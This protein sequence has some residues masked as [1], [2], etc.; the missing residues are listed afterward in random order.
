ML[1]QHDLGLYEKALN[2]ALSWLDR[3]STAKSLGFDFV[4]ISIDESDERLARLDWSPAERA[5]L[6]QAIRESGVPLRSMCLSAHR[7]FPF[8]SAD[9]D[10]RARAYDIMAKAVDFAL[11]FNIR[12][13]QLAGYDVYYEDSTEE[14]RQAFLEGLQWSCRL[15][16]QKQ[17]MLAM[18]IMD[19]PFLNSITKN[20]WYEQQLR[21][22]WY[23]VYPDL[24]N[25]FAWGN[26][27]ERELE[28]GRGSIVA[29]H[30]KETLAVRPGFPGKFKCVPF[31]TGC[32]DFSACFRKLEE[33]QYKGPYLIEM[34]YDPQQDNLHEITAARK[35]VEEQYRKALAALKEE[36]E[37]P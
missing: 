20:L 31:G 17:L 11:E 30:V 3:L 2:P 13:I 22:P 8:G 37:K 29:V 4:E 36:G 35:F 32:V 24:G 15:A 34:W 33:L 1:H 9:P 21:S 5:A 28:K 7:R 6:H 19:T 26:D 12:V 10:I 23:A 16:E 27:V 14:S 25:L 18:E